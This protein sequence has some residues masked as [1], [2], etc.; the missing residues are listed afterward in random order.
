MVTATPA[1]P[2]PPTRPATSDRGPRHRPGE[3]SGLLFVLPF[4]IV[5][6]VF[7]V[8][9]VIAGLVN[10]FFNK[11]LAGTPS[12]FLGLANWR[13]LFG[14]PA[15]W[16]SLGN[17]ALFT[18]LS[19]PLLV[20]TGLAM[21]LLAH[22]ARR[23][24]WLLRFSYFAPFVLPA[25]V[26]SLIWV[27]LY[28]PEFGLLNSWIE[29]LGGSAVPWLTTEGVA[30]V[31]IVVTTTWWTVGFNFL[32]YLAALQQIPRDLYEAA[33]LDGASARQQLWHI[34]LPQLRRT[35]GLIVVLQ[36]LASLRVF[37]QVYLMTEGGPN[38]TTRPV[39]QYIYETGFTSFR[40]GY[41][42]AI[43]YLLFVIILLLAVF[44]LRLTVRNRSES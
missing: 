27:W 2:A 33:S 13:E 26:V 41:A 8:W 32:L 5:F 17:T 35:T 12:Q 43:S 28:Q 4:M 21:A 40:L 10:S 30:M 16:Q 19:T 34:T 38:S 25:T 39:L 7:M 3:T 14:D 9:P 20:V 11:S 37:D 42:S 29:A 6:A 18:L 23:L 31:A 15:V 44:Q 22:R 24:G 1:A 36:V